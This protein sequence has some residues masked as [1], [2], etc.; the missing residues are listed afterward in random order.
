MTSV[1]LRGRK[2]Y[3]YGVL[4]N[5]LNRGQHSSVGSNLRLSLGLMVAVRVTIWHTLDG[6]FVRATAPITG[7]YR[8]HSFKYLSDL[9]LYPLTLVVIIRIELLN[10]FTYYDGEYLYLSMTEN[11][12][13][14]IGVTLFKK[15]TNYTHGELQ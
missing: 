15:K 1:N 10:C 11:D 7:K 13:A 9:P 2:Y 8:S 6:T 4:N 3:L 14:I 5:N 12:R